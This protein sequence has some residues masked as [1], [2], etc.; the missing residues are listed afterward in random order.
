MTSNTIAL[1]LLDHFGV[2]LLDDPSERFAPPI[3]Q[4][5]DSRIY[6]LRGRVCSLS[7]LRRLLG[8]PFGRD[9]ELLDHGFAHWSILLS[10]SSRS[11]N[12]LCQNPAIWL[13][14]SIRGASAP[15]CAL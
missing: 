2:S 15:S 6:Q 14:Q 7:F 13:V 3:I 11:S 5:L 4:L 8:H 9:G 12:R 1:P 10:R